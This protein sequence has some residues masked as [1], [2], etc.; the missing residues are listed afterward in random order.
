MSGSFEWNVE[1]PSDRMILETARAWGVSPSTFMG[2]QKVAVTEQFGAQKLTTYRSEWTDEDRKAAL[3]L[4]AYESELC[5]GCGHPMSE[6]TAPENEFKYRAE[7]P[8]RC[9][10]CTA[11]GVA[12]A[13]YEDAPQASALFIPVHLREPKPVEPEGS[14]D[15]S[16]RSEGIG[17]S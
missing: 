3:E 7:L 11:S 2:S 5:P 15:V 9:H 1:D 16:N 4:A 10:R 6:T 12:M 14:D 13:V 8:I 17:S